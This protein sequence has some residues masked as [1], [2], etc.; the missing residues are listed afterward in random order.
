MNMLTTG[1]VMTN[2]RGMP[3][4]M[5]KGAGKKMEKGDFLAYRK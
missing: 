2:R 4:E 1:T 3:N 5:K